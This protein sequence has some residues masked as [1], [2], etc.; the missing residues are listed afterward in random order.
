M[1]MTSALVARSLKRILRYSEWALV[2]RL[3]LGEIEYSAHSSIEHLA[4]AIRITIVS[5]D[6]H[7]LYRRGARVF[8]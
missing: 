2:D 5:V 7:V 4:S 6:V 1:F 3:K 8:V